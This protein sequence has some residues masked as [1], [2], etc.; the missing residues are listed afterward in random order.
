M[1]VKKLFSDDKDEFEKERSILAAMGRKKHPHLIKLLATYKYDGKYH[2]MFPFANANLRTYWDSRRNPDFNRQTV[3]WSVQQMA[4]IASGLLR[5]HNFNVTLPL[6][7]AGPGNVRVQ[8]DAKLSVKKGEELFGRH[9]DMKP[10]NVLWFA[11]DRETHNPDGILQIA[12]FGLGRFHGR[13]SRSHFNPDSFKI[14][15]PTYEPPECQLRLSVSRAYDMWSLGCLYLEFITWLLK[16]YLQ[17]EG[18]SDFR[19]REATTTGINDDNFFTIINDDQGLRA[20]VREEVITWTNQLHSHPKCSPLIH[21]LLDLTMQG[22]LV[23]DA[24]ERF[25]ASWLQIKF[26]ECLSKAQQDEDY[27]LKSAPRIIRPD[28]QSRADSAPEPLKTARPHANTN[29]KRSPVVTFAHQKSSIKNNVHITLPRDLVLRTSG[30][31]N[32][33]NTWPAHGTQ[34]LVREIPR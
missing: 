3:L 18:F 1:A 27:L 6:S 28:A 2:L 17:I 10:E 21:D 24:S 34:T 33:T 20:T 25:P 9:G 7:V 13:D 11:D 22:L 23:V 14:G 19:G 12:D 5:I 30:T 32:H 16:G 26:D 15:S 29:P 31:P 4:G 8:R